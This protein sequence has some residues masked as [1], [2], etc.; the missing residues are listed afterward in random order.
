MES[1]REKTD[2]QE[3]E[4]TMAT[5]TNRIMNMSFLMNRISND[6]KY[7]SNPSDSTGGINLIEEA[8]TVVPGENNIYSYGS[9]EISIIDRV[10]LSFN[11]MAM[12]AAA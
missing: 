2:N 3:G 11:A 12:N 8:F 7:M 9:G 1:E 6:S 4:K 10:D 5:I